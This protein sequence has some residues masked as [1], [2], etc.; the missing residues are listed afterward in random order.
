MPDRELL[1]SVTAK[2]CDWDYVR[3]SG[4]GG[5]KRNKTSSA[6]RCRHRD[7]GA[8]GYA[9]DS[10]SQHQ[11]KITAFKRMIDTKE[12]KK[13]HR[14]EVARRTGEIVEIQEKIERETKNPKITIVEVKDDDGRWIKCN[15]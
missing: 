14:L 8:I 2:D 13:W 5:Q 10:R 6:V 1:F 7:S 9:E 15:T 3:G 12:F 11:N 4:N